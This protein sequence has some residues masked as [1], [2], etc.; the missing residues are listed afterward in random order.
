M[1]V[2]GIVLAIMTLKIFPFEHMP[3]IL[4]MIQFTFRLLEFTSF[5]FA[6]VSA[7]NIV[8]VCK[9]NLRELIILLVALMI[10]TIPYK[11]HIRTLETFDE[12]ILWPS[13]PVTQETGRVHSGLASFEYLPS[14][15]FENRKYIETRTQ[16]AIVMNENSSTIIESQVK[17]GTKMSFNVKYV[18]EETE[19]ELPYIY[20]LGYDVTLKTANEKIKL[21]TFETNNGFIGIKLPILEEGK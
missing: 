12:N 14:K 16:N 1:L 11:N 21:Q 6:F 2:T 8:T 20:Y 15:A 3:S 7:I 10:L 13:V 5:L 9:I 19:I 18:L 4:K 17:N